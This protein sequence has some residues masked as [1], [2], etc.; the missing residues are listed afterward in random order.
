VIECVINVSEGRDLDLLDD[1]HLLAGE[2]LR[3]LHADGHH[4]R[5]V[6]TLINDATALVRDVRSLLAGAFDVLDLR[7]HEGVH[8]RFGV[9]D[10]VPFVALDP[11]SPA[12]ALAL[13]DDTARWLSDEFQVPVFLYG[14]IGEQIRTLPEVR[15]HAFDDLAPDF[16]PASASPV[17]GAVAVGARPV[18]IA[19]NIWLSGVSRDETRAL[20]KAVRRH[21]VR[22]LAFRAGEHTQ[23]SCNLIDPLVVGPAAVYDAVAQRLPEGG[24][25]DRCELVGLVPRAVLDAVERGRWEQ[26]GLSANQTI[27]SRL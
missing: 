6:F 20:A 10:V 8:P 7:T 1:L 24:E 15:R 19:W 17:L 2:S 18:L 3:D 21:E 11:E 9:V 16:G 27:E 14:Q 26:L 22:A 13:R 23:V 12:R 25:I 4:N 5:S